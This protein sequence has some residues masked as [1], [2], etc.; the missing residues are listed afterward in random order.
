[1]GIK[2]THA[3]MKYAFALAIL[4]V[5]VSASPMVQNRKLAQTKA[6]ITAQLTQFYQSEG[7]A[8][9][10]SKA[11]EVSQRIVGIYNDSTL[12]VQQKAQKVR[13]AIAER[14]GQVNREKLNQIFRQVLQ[15]TQAMYQPWVEQGQQWI[16]S[17]WGN[18][19]GSF[20]AWK[21][22]MRGG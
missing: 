6:Q 8:N 14:A 1:M 5:A 9:A 2:Q 4:L 10:K 18:A 20:E 17:K 21:Q 19:R 12:N 3:V 13:Q 15:K 11:R 7:V 16:N 22:G